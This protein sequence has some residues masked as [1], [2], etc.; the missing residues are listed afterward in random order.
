MANVTQSIAVHAPVEKI[1]DI[2]SNFGRYPEFLAEIVRADVLSSSPTKA[3]VAFTA[4]V[5]KRIDYTMAFEIR[6]PKEIRWTMVDGDMLIRSNDGSWKFEALEKNLTDLTF[7]CEMHFNI[8]LPKSIAEGVITSHLPAMMKNF[9]EQ[10]EKPEGKADR[11]KPKA[12][13]VARASGLVSRKKRAKARSG[14][15]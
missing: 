11:K 15:K 4:N 8:W 12:N 7:S 1:F 14:K 5:I 2:V 6:R 3:K 10:A 13:Q 9:K